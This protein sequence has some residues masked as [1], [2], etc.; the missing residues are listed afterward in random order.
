[1]PAWATFAGIAGVVLALLIFLAYASQ[2][3][4]DEPTARAH[5]ASLETSGSFAPTPGVSPERELQ[6]E[7]LEVGDHRYVETERVPGGTTDAERELST[8]ALLANV[9]LTQGLLGALLLGGLWY[10]QVPLT[11]IGVTPLDAGVVATGVGLGLALAVGNDAVSVVAERLGAPYAEELRELLAPDSPGEW[12]LLLALVLPVI[13][14][15]EEL[16]FRGVLIGGVATGF[17]V[18]LWLLAVGSTVVFALGHGA[19]GRVGILVTGL[20]G[21]VLA[22][23]FVL[24]GSLFVVIIAHYLVNALEF[25]LHEGLGIDWTT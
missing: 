6:L 14:G 2:R 12:L 3:I 5:P 17:G 1:M 20:L 18:S 9:A 16:L 23:A 19:Q 11:A 24:T 7:N 10:T 25:V 15:F 13:A 21:F 22:A 8:G 4:V